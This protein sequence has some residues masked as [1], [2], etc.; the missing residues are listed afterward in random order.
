MMLDLSVSSFT[1]VLAIILAAFLTRL[2]VTPPNPPPQGTW[3]KDGIAPFAGTTAVAFYRVLVIVCTSY[4]ALLVLLP[5]QSSLY[6]CPN[7]DRLNPSLFTWNLYTAFW[8]FALICVGAPVRISSYRELGRN[9]NFRL[10]SPD[11][12]I[13]TGIYKHIQHPSYTGLIAIAA[14]AVSLFGRWDGAIGCWLP[15]TILEMVRGWGFAT[16][17]ASMLVLFVA[18]AKRVKDEEEMMRQV[19]GRQWVQ[20]HE[21]TK[22]F[23][24]GLL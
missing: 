15:E 21:S 5:P 11:R 13:T 22:R 10:S 8:L 14:A 18:V 17:N 7:R 20:W 4:H 12:L 1:F 6:M 2:A 24:P 9:F 19:F 3:M 16:I 23:V